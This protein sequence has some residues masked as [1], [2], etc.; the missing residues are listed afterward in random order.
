MNEKTKTG[1]EILQAAVL[2]GILG[3]VLLR[4]TPWGLNVFLFI[5]AL[6]AAMIMLI[7]RRRQEF[8]NGQTILLNGALVFFAAM[9]VWRDSIEL[10]I[11]DTLAILTIL[12]VLT[13]PALKIKTQIAGVFHYFIGF[14]WSGISAAFAPFFLI[15][16]DVGFQTI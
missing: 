6:A 1:L 2:L 10:K 14:L 8:W 3:D 4:A 7:L 15:F 11:F 5:G 16:N 9:F 12:A 13:L